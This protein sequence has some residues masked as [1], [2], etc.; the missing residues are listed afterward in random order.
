M[1]ASFDRN[2]LGINNRN[3]TLKIIESVSKVKA[4][5]SKEY[6]LEYLS[7]PGSIAYAA[8]ICTIA[9]IGVFGA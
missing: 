7:H 3:Y 9:T 1:I 6:F 8:F 4:K 2:F 5:T